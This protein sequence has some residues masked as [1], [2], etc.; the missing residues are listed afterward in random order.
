MNGT[1]VTVDRAHPTAEALAVAADGTI[2]AVRSLDIVR[3]T[4]DPRGTTA[5]VDTSQINHSPAIGIG[6]GGE[7]TVQVGCSHFNLLNLNP[8]AASISSFGTC[9]T[10]CAKV[11]W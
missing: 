6:Q 3:K 9:R 2:L 10:G 8:V 1:V 5:V 7:R 11:Q 4:T